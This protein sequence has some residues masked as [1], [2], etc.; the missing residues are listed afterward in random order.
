VAYVF[1]NIVV[2]AATTLGVLWLWN[3]AH[4]TPVF[5]RNQLIPTTPAVTST[6][7]QGSSQTNQ[8]AN[9]LPAV[10]PLTQEFIT[11]VNI[12]GVGSLA[13]EYVLVKS[14]TQQSLDLTNWTLDDNQGDK[15]IFPRL[16]LIN[17]GAV[18][19]HTM[20]GVDSVIDL[21]WGRDAPVWQSGMTA[22]LK[23]TQGIERA[24]YTIP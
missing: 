12:Y 4:P 5:P 21:Y 19:V 11:I 17:G 6:Q 24:R 2:S 13:D 15:Y 18:Q 3:Q 8:P 22:I 10:L 7:F 14:V 16:T 1:L 20:A 23:D 9:T